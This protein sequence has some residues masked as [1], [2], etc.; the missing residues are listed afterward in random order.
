MIALI[1]LVT[2]LTIGLLGVGRSGRELRESVQMVSAQLR[3]ART[4][5]LVTGKPQRFAMDLDHRTWTAIDHHGT[6]PKGMQVAFS[7]V[8]EEQ[9][10]AREAAIRFFPDGSSTGGRVSLREKGSGWRVDVRWL[11]GEVTAERLPDGAP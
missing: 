11:T 4:R 2:G 6:L 7:S 8:R 10:S 5:A 3:Y 9:T 1:A